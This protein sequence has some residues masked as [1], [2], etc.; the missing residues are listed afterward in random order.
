MATRTLFYAITCDECGVLKFFEAG[1][2]LPYIHSHG[3]YYCRAQ[4][5]PT[6]PEGEQKIDPEQVQKTYREYMASAIGE[7]GPV[8]GMHFSDWG[9]RIAWHNAVALYGSIARNATKS[10]QHRSNARATL[11]VMRRIKDE[12]RA[13][14]IINAVVHRYRGLWIVYRPGS[15]G[16]IQVGPTAYALLSDQTPTRG[17]LQHLRRVAEW[18]NGGLELAEAR[19]EPDPFALALA[20]KSSSA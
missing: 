14:G 18:L 13:R 8:F 6:C 7:V 15:T 9:E 17:T 19:G 20:C 11:R 16:V 4:C 5:R 3:G 2:A 1:K 10:S 12:A